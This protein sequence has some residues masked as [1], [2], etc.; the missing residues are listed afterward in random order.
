MMRSEINLIALNEWDNSLFDDFVIPVD[1]DNNPIVDKST[2]IDNLLMETAELEVVYNNPLFMKF[3]IGKWSSKQAPVWLEIWK[4]TQYEYNPIWNKDG[5]FDETITR[6]LANS[7][8]KSEDYTTTND[9]TRTNDLSHST[10]ITRTDDLSG[11][12]DTTVDSSTYGFNSSTAAP[13]DQ[14]VEDTDTTQTGTVRNAGTDTDTGTI[15]DTGTVRNAGSTD[16][17]GTDTG[18]ITTSRTEQGN[19][20]TTSTQSLIMEQREVVKLN[21]MDVIIHDFRNRFCILVY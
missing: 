14:S 19:I 4:T 15:K 13:T 16:S 10:D 12:V 21:I 18:T 9:L 7:L 2:L 20:G 8:N 17:S 5:T 1:D 11:T 3:A 6:D